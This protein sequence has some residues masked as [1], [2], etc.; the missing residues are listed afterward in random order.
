MAW[1]EERFEQAKKLWS[2]GE[3]AS[4]IGAKLGLT[5][6]S[7]LAKLWRAGLVKKSDRP[8]TKASRIPRKPARR[9]FNSPPA[10]TPQPRTAFTKPRAEP[11]EGPV[12]DVDPIVVHEELDIP[13]AE[14]KSLVDLEANDCRWPIGDPKHK[15]FH[16]CGRS[17]VAGLPYCEHHARRAYQP[18]TA[19]RPS[20]ASQEQRVAKRDLAD[21]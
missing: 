4:Q 20:P 14:R 6:N 12:F 16:F 9:M 8:S 3:S 11:F 2:Q 19:R 21:A 7:V 18:A 10:A 17:K 13:L 1:T 15:D 5:R